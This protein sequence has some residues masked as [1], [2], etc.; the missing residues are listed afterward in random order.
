MLSPG[1][2]EFKCCL[3]LLSETRVET[4]IVPSDGAEE[5]VNQ[6]SLSSL[7]SPSWGRTQPWFW[8]AIHVSPPVSKTNVR[9]LPASSCEEISLT[10]V[11]F[12]LSPLTKFIIAHRI[13]ESGAVGLLR[14]N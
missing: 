13:F 7:I 2:S 11:F 9:T 4:F 8:P 1:F 6:C 14:G 12:L 3:Y 10:G 5:T